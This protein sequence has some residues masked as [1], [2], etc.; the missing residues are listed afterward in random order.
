[1]KTSSLVIKNL[2]KKFDNRAV[3]DKLS[4]EVNPSEIYALIGPNGAGKTTTIKTVLGLYSKDGGEVIF[5]G[6][7]IKH[8][9]Y[10]PDEPLFYPYLTGWEVLEFTRILNKVSENN[11]KKKLRELLTSFPIESFL[12][13]YPES[14]SRGNKQKL[15]IIA[16]FLHTPKVLLIDEPVVGLDPES[17]EKA[18]LLFS[19]FAK[20]GG[21]ILVSTHTLSFVEK[22][23]TTIGIIKNGKIIFEGKP[24]D[25]IKK[26]KGSKTVFDAYI[27]LTK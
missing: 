2:T 4:L 23:A 10:I 1:M 3:L 19:N 25:L 11:Y 7:D 18:A 13:Y 17:S 20:E 15:S 14:Y 12:S 26:A 27:S 9:G 22:V 5:N 24:H 16:A 8:L 21:I 6:F